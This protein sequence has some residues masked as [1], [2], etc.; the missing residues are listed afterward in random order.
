VAA[1][2][3]DEQC[4]EWLRWG[5]GDGD[6]RASRNESGK[7]RQE[8]DVIYGVIHTLINVIVVQRRL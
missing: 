7:H 4:L 1:T 3:G 5:S 2:A 8:T 6:G